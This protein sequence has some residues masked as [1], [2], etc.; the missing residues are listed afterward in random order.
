MRYRILGFI[1]FLIFLGLGSRFVANTIV[2]KTGEVID[3]SLDKAVNANYE[4]K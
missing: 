3:K 1:I 4:V 2:N